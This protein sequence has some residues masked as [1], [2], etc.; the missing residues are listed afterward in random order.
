MRPR[1]CMQCAGRLTTVKGRPLRECRRCGWIYWNNP[2]PT[3][4]VI[5]L[6]ER[7][8]L[9]AKRAISPFRGYWDLVGG[10]IEPGETA[11]QAARRESREELGVDIELERFF[12]TFPGSYGPGGIATLDVCYVGRIVGNPSQVTVQDDV[13]AV[14]WFPI[15]RLPKRITAPTRAILRQLSRAIRDP[16]PARKGRGSTSSPA[17]ME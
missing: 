10:F 14:E 3:A 17:G 8:V 5:I 4:S 6:E 13:A 16:A 2:K 7:R 11:E 12:G 15:G 1:F 9:L